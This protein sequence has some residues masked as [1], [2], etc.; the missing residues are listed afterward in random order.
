MLGTAFAPNGHLWLATTALPETSGFTTELRGKTALVE[1]DRAND[2]VLTRS[3][4]LPTIRLSTASATSQ[5][6]PDGTVFVSD[7]VGTILSC[8]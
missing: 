3:S 7:G 6:R 1:I 8:R 5:L 4:R 2:S